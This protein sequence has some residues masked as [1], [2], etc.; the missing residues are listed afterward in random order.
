MVPQ[1]PD[2]I[3]PLVPLRGI[4]TAK[5]SDCPAVE[6]PAASTPALWTMSV[7]TGRSAVSGRYEHRHPL[8]R[9]LPPQALEELVGRT[10]FLFAGA[11]AQRAGVVQEAFQRRRLIATFWN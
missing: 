7:T 2:K 8:R 5:A 6:L 1:R 11:E 3:D 10:Q 4:L 9:G